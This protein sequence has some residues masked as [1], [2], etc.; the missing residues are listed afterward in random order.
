M[1][2]PARSSAPA[3][4]ARDSWIPLEDSVRLRAALRARLPEHVFR[5]QPWRGI[6]GFALVPVLIALGWVIRSGTLPWYGNFAV[7]LVMGQIVTVLSF[8][9]HEGYHSAVFRSKA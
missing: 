9:G 4:T 6:A 5:P 1:P 7:G 2:R 8:M 3:M